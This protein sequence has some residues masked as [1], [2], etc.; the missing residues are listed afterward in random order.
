MAGYFWVYRTPNVA[1]VALAYVTDF[2]TGSFLFGLLAAGRCLQMTLRRDCEN[3]LGVPPEARRARRGFWPAFLLIAAAT[4]WMVR[5][6]MPMRAAFSLSRPGL[7]Q[8][9]DV[10]LAD[11]K[12]AHTLAG[13]WV[14]LYRVSGV[15]VI[16]RTVVL[17]I[18]EDRGDYG[19]TRV[20]RAASDVI[21]KARGQEDDEHYHADFPERGRSDPFDHMDPEGRR[22]AGDWFVM[23]SWYWSVKVGWS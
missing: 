16:G 12:N 13:R 11:P 8:L 2:C 17:Y 5:S 20:P 19:F 22:I 4:Y 15:E 9:A 3:K 18:G 1:M 7:D 21:F 23:Y 10:A 14:G 6:E